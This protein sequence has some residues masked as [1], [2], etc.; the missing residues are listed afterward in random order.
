MVADSCRV[1]SVASL[2]SPN[3]CPVEVSVNFVWT[4][5]GQREVCGCEKLVVRHRVV[6][7]QNA[8]YF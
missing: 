2:V 1:A 7:F 5:L 8:M 4:I 6:T 3:G